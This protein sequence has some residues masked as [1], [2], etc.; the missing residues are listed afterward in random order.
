MSI[1]SKQW[2]LGRCALPHSITRGPRLMEAHLP[3]LP[4]FL[5]VSTL[6]QQSGKEKEVE[7]GCGPGREVIHMPQTR[8]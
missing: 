2:G 3:W 6:S 4:R 7:G 5:W 8:T 1:Q